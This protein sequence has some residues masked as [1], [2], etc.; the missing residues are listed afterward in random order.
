MVRFVFLCISCCIFMCMV[1]M[2]MY[3]SIACDVYV[4]FY[5][6]WF[7]SCIL[8]FVLY[9]YVY[10]FVL[11]LGPHK[12]TPPPPPLFNTFKFGFIK[13]KNLQNTHKTELVHCDLN[14]L[15]WFKSDLWGWGG[16]VWFQ[17][18]VIIC[19][20][21]CIVYFYVFWFV[22]CILHFVL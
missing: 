9:I 19:W 11:L 2:C 5:V 21:L 10:G 22:S 17:Y 3:A 1:A 6:F 20:L 7:V 18:W 8:H 4:Y 14:L 13:C 15:N 16:F 12:P